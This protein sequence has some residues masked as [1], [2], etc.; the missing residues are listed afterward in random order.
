[1]P[2]PISFEAKVFNVVG[3]GALDKKAQAMLVARDPAAAAVQ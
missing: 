3:V 2:V 1:M